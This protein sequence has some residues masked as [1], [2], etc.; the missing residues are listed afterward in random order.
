MPANKIKIDNALLKRYKRQVKKHKPRNIECRIL[1]VCEGT[2]TEPNYFNAFDR[3]NNGVF[4]NK[5]TIEG[6]GL[7]TVQV[8]DKAIEIKDKSII[9]YDRVWAVFDKDDFSDKNFNSAIN[10]AKCHNIECAWSNQAFELWY[11]YHFQNR[12]TAMHR[13]EYKNKIS[14]SVNSSPLYKSRKAYGYAKNYKANFDIMNKYGSQDNAIKWAEANS[15]K[16]GDEKFA[17]HNPCTMVFKLVRQLIGRDEDFNTW[18][19]K[20]MET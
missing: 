12:V 16:F 4:V 10:K 18:L 2:K 9:P 19:V 8:V 20:Q 5:L 17:K 14:E 15:S 13:T 1:I 6:E 3:I 11:L 7:N